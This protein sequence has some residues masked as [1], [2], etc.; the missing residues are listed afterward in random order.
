MFKTEIRVSFSN[1]E[2]CLYTIG[3][4]VLKEAEKSSEWV[5]TLF[6]FLLS[7]SSEF[8]IFFK[9]YIV[10]GLN[11]MFCQQWDMLTQK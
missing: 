1:L 2:K 5:K 11:D 10:P 8:V 7:S 3:V 6:F 4:R 9:M